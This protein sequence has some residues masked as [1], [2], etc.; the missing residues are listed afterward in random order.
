[1][2]LWPL[3]VH[4]V[5]VVLL[6]AAM[7]GLSHLLGERHRERGTD[8]PYEAGS[9]LIGGARRPLA[10]RFYLVAVLFVLFDLEA[11]YLFAWA[12][13][14]RDLGRAGYAGI[15]VF[16]LLLGAALAYLWRS[17]ALDWGARPDLRGT[18]R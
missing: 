9:P 5:A 13:V 16:I 4:A 15:L 3:A 1:M 14:A 11:I 7:L 12:L 10:A 8:R 2:P 6:A 18:G 17:G